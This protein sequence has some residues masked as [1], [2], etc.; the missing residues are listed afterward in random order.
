MTMT[1]QQQGGG[2]PYATN[3][4]KAKPTSS[5]KGGKVVPTAKIVVT[6]PPQRPICDKANNREQKSTATAKK[7]ITTT[8]TTVRI[9][10]LF[11]LCYC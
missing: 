6:V 5:G 3:V 10:A 4:R 2:W 11:F 1:E 7:T 8:Y 9:P